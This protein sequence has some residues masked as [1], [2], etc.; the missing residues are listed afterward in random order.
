MTDGTAPITWTEPD[1]QRVSDVLPVRLNGG[2]DAGMDLSGV[3]VV[4]D[5]LALGGDEGHRLQILK[6]SEA[7]D[8]WCLQHK[9]SLAKDDQETDIEALTYGDGKLYVMGSHSHRRKRLKP[10]LSVNKNLERLQMIDEEPLRNRLYKI[11]FDPKKGK[12]GVSDHID[13]TKRLRKDPILK[14]FVGIPSKENGIDI[15]G[16]AFADGHLYL[17]F[18]GP[19]LRDNYVPVML[20]DYEHPKRYELRFVQLAGQGIRDL[21]A[22]KKGLLILSGPVN[23]APGPFVLWWWDGSD[24]IPGKDREVVAAQIIGPVS[25]PG[26]AKA[27]GLGLLRQS[28]NDA[29]ILVIYETNTAAQAVRMRVDLGELTPG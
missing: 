2:I 25:T 27:E 28:D 8:E 22:L 6:C 1:R 15:E 10:E 3:V 12:L 20:L 16:L 9:L 21:V 7:P 29:E 11:S 4:G 17:G 13:L 23:D 5:F 26:G 19:V 18:R 24:Q 14:R